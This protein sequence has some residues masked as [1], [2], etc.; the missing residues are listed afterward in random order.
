[1]FT[2]PKT[3]REIILKL[4]SSLK[5]FAASHGLSPTIG[6]ASYTAD[7]LRVQITLARVIEGGI[8]ADFAREA[9]KLGLPPDLYHRTIRV[10]GEEYKVLEILPRGRKFSILGENDKG[11]RYKLSLSDVR[12]SLFPEAGEAHKKGDWVRGKTPF[13]VCYGAHTGAYVTVD[14]GTMLTCQGARLFKDDELSA[15]EPTEKELLEQIAGCYKG[16]EPENIFCDGALPLSSI[17]NRLRTL[18]S[19]LEALFTKLGRK[20]DEEEA[21]EVSRKFHGQC[22]Q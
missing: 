9:K 12:A 7:D 18:Q 22:S 20:V 10:N 17:R 6:N 5:V 8:P 2:N 13:G 11:K 3:V 16:R 14:R 19:Y 1:M 21:Y 15:W 4:E